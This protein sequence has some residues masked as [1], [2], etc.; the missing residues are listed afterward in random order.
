MLYLLSPPSKSACLPAYLPP[1]PREERGEVMGQQSADMSAILASGVQ[2]F[3]CEAAG[4]HHGVAAAFGGVFFLDLQYSDLSSSEL[5][6][7]SELEEASG[8]EH[9]DRPWW[10]WRQALSWL[11]ET[12]EEVVRYRG[13]GLHEGLAD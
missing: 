6:G 12:E 5:G 2:Q 10:H 8:S 11:G 7:G 4:G 3:S 1:G 13:P 9:P